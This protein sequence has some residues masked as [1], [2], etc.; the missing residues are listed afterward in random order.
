V[1]RQTVRFLAAANTFNDKTCPFVALCFENNRDNVQFW[2]LNFFREVEQGRISLLLR[3]VNTS[4]FWE[5]SKSA[6]DKTA[7]NEIQKTQFGQRQHTRNQNSQF[8]NSQNS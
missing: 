7:S 3:G 4:K 2:K 8:Q 5:P 6:S 1:V